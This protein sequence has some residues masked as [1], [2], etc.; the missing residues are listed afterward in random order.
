MISAV[1]VLFMLMF[2]TLT[3]TPVGNII[4]GSHSESI[5]DIDNLEPADYIV[6]LGGNV[7][8]VVDAARLYDKELAPTVILSGGYDSHISA[9]RLCGVP[10]E[11]I[12]E[13]ANAQCTAD[14]PDTIAELPDI[15]KTNKFIV[16]TDGCHFWRA[17]TVFEN[18]G[19]NNLQFFQYKPKDMK[20]RIGA[21]PKGAIDIMY[22]LAAIFE[23][24]LN[25]DL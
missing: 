8:R 7:T 14:H 20:K 11:S 3:F 5:G 10:Q 16:V 15:E 25:D 9:L 23:Y 19:Y 4:S 18:A 17:R 24:K 13:D 2:L 21:G 12:I 6:A 22:E 1:G